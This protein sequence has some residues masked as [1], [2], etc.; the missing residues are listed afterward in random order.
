MGSTGSWSIGTMVSYE[1]DYSEKGRLADFC[2][3]MAAV[4]RRDGLHEHADRWSRRAIELYD[5]VLE[6][7]VR[8]PVA[9][10]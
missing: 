4:D 1:N 7:E 3:R 6:A 9:A 2:R 8:E 5:E 10:S